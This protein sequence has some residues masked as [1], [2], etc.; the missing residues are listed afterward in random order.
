MRR[1]NS[2]RSPCFIAPPDVVRRNTSGQFVYPG[3]IF[4]ENAIARRIIHP[5]YE[6]LEVLH[7]SS[8]MIGMRVVAGPEKLVRTD[9][10]GKRRH[11]AL[12]GIGRAETLALEV[13]RGV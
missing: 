5:G 4:A 9:Q 3:R 6:S 1:A 12:E 13:V 10:F 2:V 11:A 7:I 8:R